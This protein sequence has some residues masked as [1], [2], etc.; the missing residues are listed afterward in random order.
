[1]DTWLTIASRREVRDYADEPVE[2]EAVERILQAARVTGNAR[3]RQQWRF[4]LLESRTAIATA[5]GGVTRPTN[6][7]GAALCI[8]VV[9]TGPGHTLFDGGRAAQ[10]MMLAAADIGVGSCPNSTT[11]IQLFRQL[12]SLGEEERVVTLLSFGYPA[13]RRDLEARDADAWAERADR[14]PLAELVT[15]I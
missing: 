6:V 2:P 8:A 15:R 12:L 11:D 9:L 13:R 10:N 7:E 1:V 4:V 5:A 3:N 14:K